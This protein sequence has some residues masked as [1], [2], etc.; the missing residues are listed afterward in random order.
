[1]PVVEEVWIVVEAELVVE[2][3]VE[4]VLVAVGGLLE[5]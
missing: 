4:A 2:P 3:A 5:G 1:V